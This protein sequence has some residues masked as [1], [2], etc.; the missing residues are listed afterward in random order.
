MAAALL[1]TTAPDVVPMSLIP[2]IGSAT[3][4]AES[5]SRLLAMGHDVKSH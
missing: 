2:V 4:K 1:K 3:E 5:R